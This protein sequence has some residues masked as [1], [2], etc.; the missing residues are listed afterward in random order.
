[1]IVNA[2]A[3]GGGSSPGCICVGEPISIGTGNLF[4]QVTDYQTAAAGKL[5]FVRSYNSLAPSPTFATTLGSNWRSNFDRYLGLGST[6][7]AERPDGQIISFTSNGGAWTTDTDTDLT[8]V[9]NGSDVGSI[10]MLTD[11]TDSVETYTAISATEAILTQIRARNGYTQNLQYDASAI[12]LRV[13]RILLG[14]P[15][16]SRIKTAFCELSQR[17][18]VSH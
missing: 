3:A 8:L 13:S 16:N 18:T 7:A 12:I 11:H 10:W 15:C 2:K 5:S 1:M 14:A 17:P 9:S 4:E 6:V